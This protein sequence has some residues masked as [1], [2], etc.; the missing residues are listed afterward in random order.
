MAL[1]VSILDSLSYK[2]EN[3]FLWPDHLE[4]G[5]LC[6]LDQAITVQLPNGKKTKKE[7]IVA[8]LKDKEMQVVNIRNKV[9]SSAF[10]LNIYVQT[11]AVP[12]QCGESKCQLH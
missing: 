7:L 5:C 1:Q 12:F 6:S 8:L 4:K 10:S 2:S 9:C 3:I 11:Y